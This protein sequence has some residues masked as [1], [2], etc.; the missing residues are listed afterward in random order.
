MVF[1]APMIWGVGQGQSGKKLCGT[2]NFLRQKQLP[3][4]LRNTAE[5]EQEPSF[6]RSFMT[7]GDK[8]NLESRL[9]GIALL[10]CHPVPGRPGKSLRA[11]VL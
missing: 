7:A 4:G 5:P 10:F 9:P 6:G 3:V 2:K 1:S 8:T 11:I